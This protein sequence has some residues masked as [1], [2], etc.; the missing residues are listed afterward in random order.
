MLFTC[1]LPICKHRHGDKEPHNARDALCGW[2]RF[3]GFMPCV[4]SSRAKTRK[5]RRQSTC[6]ASQSG[7]KSLSLSPQSNPHTL[8]SCCRTLRILK[9]LTLSNQLQDTDVRG[10]FDSICSQS[11]SSQNI[12]QTHFWCTHFFSIELSAALQDTDVWLVAP[13]LVWEST[14]A[15]VCTCGD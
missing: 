11:Q 3:W 6:Q 8:Q 7:W 14:C 12:F 15:C 4:L 2:I 5:R 9:V 13:V 10:L 1:I